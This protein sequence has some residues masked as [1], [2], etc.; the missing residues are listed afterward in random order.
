[1]SHL[2]RHTR[3][4]LHSLR[5]GHRWHPMPG[6]RQSHYRAVRPLRR[7]EA[8]VRL[9]PDAIASGVVA[10]IVVVPSAVLLSSFL[11]AGA[12]VVFAVPSGWAVARLRLASLRERNVPA[13]VPSFLSG[14]RAHRSARGRWAIYLEAAMPGRSVSGTNEAAEIRCAAC[15][16]R[17]PS[18]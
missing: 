10:V 4:R 3:R 8:A 15:P 16:W 12:A 1:M 13:K 17:F 9:S 5:P 14:P 2:Y 6:G 7:L 18:R 11:G